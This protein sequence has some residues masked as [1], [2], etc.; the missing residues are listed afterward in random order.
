MSQTHMKTLCTCIN[1]ILMFLLPQGKEENLTCALT[2]PPDKFSP[3]GLMKLL[4]RIPMTI[5][6]AK[7]AS[8]M[9][10]SVLSHRLSCTNIPSLSYFFKRHR[11]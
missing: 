5:V 10:L 7:S 3:L 9:L 2:S 6:R 1:I 8:A 11:F 4:D